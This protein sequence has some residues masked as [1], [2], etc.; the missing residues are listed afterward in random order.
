MTAATYSLTFTGRILQRGFWL[1]VWEVTLA[2][3][4]TLHYVGRTGDSSSRFAQSPFTRMGQHLG[5]AE[6]SSMLRRHLTARGVTP[7]ACTYRLVAHGPVLEEAA[8]LA[9]H[10]ERRDVVSALEKA[11]AEA[12]AAAGYTVMNT[13]KCRQRLDEELFA[14]VRA[15]FA[16]EF[17]ALRVDC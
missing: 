5:F 13:V 8:D 15:A 10:R 2:G 6:N 9:G 16:A 3:S 11:L 4:S 17:P 12:M 1:Y 7:E 14:Q